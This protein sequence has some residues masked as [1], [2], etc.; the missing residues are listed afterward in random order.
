MGLEKE[1]IEMFEKALNHA[2]LDVYNRE[3]LEFYRFHDLERA[4][5]AFAKLRILEQVKR[6][7]TEGDEQSGLYCTDSRVAIRRN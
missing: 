5:T 3:L 2:H 4:N 1:A 6:K 7:I